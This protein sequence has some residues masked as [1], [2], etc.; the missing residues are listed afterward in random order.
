MVIVRLVNIKSTATL[1]F[2][3]WILFQPAARNNLTNVDPST[4]ENMNCA[5]HVNDQIYNEANLLNI[6]F[7]HAALGHEKPH[8]VRDGAIYGPNLEESEQLEPVKCVR[9]IAHE[10]WDGRTHIEDHRSFRIVF[11]QLKDPLFPVAISHERCNEVQQNV[12][13]KEDVDD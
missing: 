12:N 9:L 2:V 3:V 1:W 4:P 6:T 5:E 10:S 7:V 11:D 13:C 8:H